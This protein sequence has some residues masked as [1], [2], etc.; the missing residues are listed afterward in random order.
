MRPGPKL[1]IVG[2]LAIAI[3]W[4]FAGNPRDWFGRGATAPAVAT[5]SAAPQ[6]L[7]APEPEPEPP[8]PP[9]DAM[10]EF[11]SA[12][13]A[14]AE[15]TWTQIFAEESDT[16]IPPRLRYFDGTTRSGCG[17]AVDGDGTFY[18]APDRRLYIDKDFH[19]G[20]ADRGA[21]AGSFAHAYVLAHGIGHHVQNLRGIE[22]RLRK[23]QAGKNAAGRKAL[24][25]RAE[26]QA[27]C[28]AGIW[29][30]NARKGSNAVTPA[31]LDQAL[32]L[33]ASIGIEL[34]KR[35]EPGVIVPD[36][37]SHGT[38]P[39][40]KRWFLAGYKHGLVKNCDTFGSRR[41]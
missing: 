41:F 39:Q 8:P 26:L 30:H 16:Y 18:C 6:P 20:M 15:E 33:P 40:R 4:F 32:S 27:D 24:Q 21:P 23:E 37:Y 31:E 14:E 5:P 7:P 22:D 1:T 38:L 29:A 36:P 25:V 11:T 2:V 9:R 19:R 35:H 12:V 28:F 3:A 17:E 10:D 34:M 13:L